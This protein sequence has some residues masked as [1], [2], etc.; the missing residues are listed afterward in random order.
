VHGQRD[1]HQGCR[2][3]G[4]IGNTPPD[5]ERFDRHVKACRDALV[6]E[7][8]GKLG[9]PILGDIAPPDTVGAA[10]IGHARARLATSVAALAHSD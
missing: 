10:A 1:Q 5:V 7:V 3:R 2:R 8:L 6:G 9:V 4:H